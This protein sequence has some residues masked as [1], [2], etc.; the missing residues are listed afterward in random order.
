MENF[1]F[2]YILVYEL[3]LYFILMY[4]INFDVIL[5]SKFKVW[6]LKLIIYVD[7]FSV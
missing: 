3:F 2:W 6:L 7:V 4:L 5:N 1:C